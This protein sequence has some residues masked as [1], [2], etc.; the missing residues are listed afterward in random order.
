MRHSPVA[1]WCC[2]TIFWRL[3][4]R[5]P[6]AATSGS[7][8][9]LFKGVPTLGMVASWPLEAR[10][11]VCLPAT[12]TTPTAQTMKKNIDERI[13]GGSDVRMGGGRRGEGTQR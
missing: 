9:A 13:F 12:C 4:F 7:K 5:A 3:V 1:S 2:A 8:F 11:A 6:V 10:R